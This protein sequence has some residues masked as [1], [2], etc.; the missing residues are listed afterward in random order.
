MAFSAE[1]FGRLRASIFRIPPS[2]ARQ[3]QSN[4]SASACHYETGPIVI[5]IEIYVVISIC[6]VITHIS[7]CQLE[8]KI[9]G[10]QIFWNLP[11]TSLF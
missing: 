9:I 7:Q 1:N 4:S 8:L 11:H 5:T 10:I 2:T 6:M 3:K